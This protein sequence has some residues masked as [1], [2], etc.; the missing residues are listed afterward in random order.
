MVKKKG[1]VIIAVTLNNN[2]QLY[3]VLNGKDSFGFTKNILKATKL[4]EIE[5]R[6]ILNSLRS[7]GKKELNYKLIDSKFINKC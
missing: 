7:L 3:L 1:T 4:L 6:K 2:H 5:A